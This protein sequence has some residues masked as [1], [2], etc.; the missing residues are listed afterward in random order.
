M[1]PNENENRQHPMLWIPDHAVLFNPTDSL[2]AYG[3]KRWPTTEGIGTISTTRKDALRH[4]EIVA[5]TYEHIGDSPFLAGPRRFKLVDGELVEEQGNT[6]ASAK[7][8]LGASDL[9]LVD[10][11]CGHD[12]VSAT[13]A[14]LSR[15]TS[16]FLDTQVTFRIANGDAPSTHSSQI[17]IE[18]LNEMIEP[19]ILKDT[20]S[21]I[22]VGG[23]AM[24]KGCPFL[25]IAGRNPYW[26]TPEARVITLEVFG[27]IPYPR[28]NSKFRKPRDAIASDHIVPRR[29]GMSS[30][31]DDAHDVNVEEATIPLVDPPPPN[32]V[33]GNSEDPGEDDDEITSRNLRHEAKS[34]R[35]LLTHKPAN[36]YCGACILGKIR[37]TKKFCGSFERSRQPIRWLEL[38]TADHLVAQR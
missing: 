33:E 28:R 17:F 8:R 18:E 9:W 5:A 30:V 38:V 20:P 25:W 13:N 12:L 2:A 11:G 7:A 22:S 6:A 1:V 32:V 31:N 21:V 23:R 37:G 16:K 29:K 19:F 14:K 4:S 26:I 24:G 3:R 35:H 27:D 34:M 10:T 36:K 15:G